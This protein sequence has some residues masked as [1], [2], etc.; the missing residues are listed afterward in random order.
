MPQPARGMPK[1]QEHFVQ[2]DGLRT[3]AVSSVAWSH[4]ASSRYLFGL[5]W[6]T[7][8]QL[9]FVLSGF[10]I[11]GILMDATPEEPNQSLSSRFG[12]WRSFYARRFLR[13]FPLYYAVLAVAFLLGVGPIATTWKWHVA[14]LSNFFF[15]H[16]GG[17]GNPI[18]PFRHFWSLAVEEQFYLVWP[19]L[20]LLLSRGTLLKVLIGMIVTAP[21]F[22]IV[23]YWV[24]ID[25]QMIHL[26]PFSCLDALGIG[27]LFAYL[28]RSPISTNR[29][30]R[31][32][33][34]LC[35]WFGL[36]GCL[37]F[38][39]LERTLNESFIAG[40]I[41][42]FCLVLFYGW[43]VYQATLGFKG[44]AGLF[45]RSRVM[46]YLGKISYGLYVFHHFAP[47][48]TSMIAH[49]IGVSALLG[50]S[51]PL[52]LFLNVFFTLILAMSSWHLLESPLNKLKRHFPYTQLQQV[53]K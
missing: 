28:M 41:G 34:G 2:L 3:L 35:L 4:W 26:L 17:W 38:T 40:S 45:L 9:F 43:V 47:F 12:I 48:A 22:R 33:A 49:Q 52:Q 50:A 23:M 36:L 15:V 39:F 1:G 7:G 14:Y 18:D 13:I 37:V 24:G 25:V 27:S 46:A 5:P 32:L 29:Q 20:I 53:S 31:R 21:L 19:F 44:F 11:T 6:G 8:V 30:A 16:Q 10:L 42:H 51:V